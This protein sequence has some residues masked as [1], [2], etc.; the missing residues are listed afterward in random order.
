MARHVLVVRGAAEVLV[1]PRLAVRGPR[2]PNPTWRRKQ[3]AYDVHSGTQQF[4]RCDPVADTHHERPETARIDDGCNAALEKHPQ[5]GRQTLG[6][7]LFHVSVAGNSSGEGH[8]HVE[9]G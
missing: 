7:E 4:P 9:I 2:G 6:H 1:A 8:V 3:P 5:S